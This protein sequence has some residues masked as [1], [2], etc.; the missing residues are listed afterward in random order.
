MHCGKYH[1]S[2]HFLFRKN[3]FKMTIEKIVLLSLGLLLILL[4]N[5]SCVSVSQVDAELEANAGIA[6]I[7]E[8][9]LNTLKSLASQQ[10]ISNCFSSDIEGQQI[11]LSDANFSLKD[12]ITMYYVSIIM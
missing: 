1:Y 12:L 4:G 3:P 7:G 6:R 5:V 10:N 2:Q 8:N 11:D 9:A